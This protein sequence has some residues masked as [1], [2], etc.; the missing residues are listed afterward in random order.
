MLL[1]RMSRDQRHLLPL[2]RRLLLLQLS[3]PRAI[4]L[5]RLPLRVLLPPRRRS[6]V[7]AI[8]HVSPHCRL[9]CGWTP[10]SSVHFFPRQALDMGQVQGL[11]RCGSCFWTTRMVA[12]VAAASSCRPFAGIRRHDAE[13]LDHRT[14]QKYA[15]CKL[16]I[17]SRP[18]AVLLPFTLW[19]NLCA[20]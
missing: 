17:R 11:D 3:G 7:L 20:L 19:S 14:R 9:R 6:A 2:S 12:L 15:G 18:I 13:V 1:P 4:Q 5:P 16:I 8:D 10:R